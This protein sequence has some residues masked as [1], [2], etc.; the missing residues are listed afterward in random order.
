[1]NRF[2]AWPESALIDI[3]ESIV[4]TNSS[5]EESKEEAK[6]EESNKALCTQIAAIH[7]ACESF[8]DSYAKKRHKSA[9]SVT[10]TSFISFLKCFNQMYA[11][12][13]AEL[14]EKDRRINLGMQKMSKGALDVDV[15]KTELEKLTETLEQSKKATN[16]M[17]AKLQEKSLETKRQGDVMERFR[18]KCDRDVIRIKKERESCEADLAKAMP[19][20]RKAEEAIQA[21]S[22]D[23]ITVIKRLTTPA[24]IIQLVFDCVCIIF[25]RPLDIVKETK[26]TIAKEEITFLQTSHASASH[27]ISSASFLKNLLNFGT[28]RKDEINEETM[29]LLEPY[30][31]LKHFDP[32]VAKKASSAAEGL[33]KWVHSMK[34]YYDSSK[35]AKPKLDA[36]AISEAELE[37]AQRELSDA[38]SKFQHL[39]V[40]LN[41]L[42]SNFEMAMAKKQALVDRSASTAQRIQQASQLI[43][44]LSSERERWQ[45]EAGMF[46][47]KKKTLMGDC[48]LASAFLSYAGPLDYESRM[49]L[50]ED[51]IVQSLESSGVPFTK[52]LNVVEFLVNREKVSNW[53]LNGLASDALS[54]QNAILVCTPS[55]NNSP[56]ILIDPEGQALRWLLEMEKENLPKWGTSTSGDPKLK[57]QLEFNLSE[58]RTMI[59]TNVETQRLDPVLLS[60]LRNRIVRKGDANY[61]NL[62]GSMCA[63]HEKFKLYFVTEE[64]RPGLSA[65]VLNQTRIV[66]FT[67]TSKALEDQLLADVVSKEQNVLETQMRRCSDQIASDTSSLSRLENE[68]LERLTQGEGH[69]LEDASLVSI[70]SETKSAV[71]NVKQKLGAAKQTRKSLREKREIYR[72]VATRGAVLYSTIVSCSTL[73]STYRTSINQFMRIFIKSLERAEKASL[74]P[75]RAEN[76]VQC[77]TRDVVRHVCRGMF[78]NHRVAFLFLLAM[79][80]MNK[81]EIAKNTFDLFLELG[82]D[83]DI[84]TVPKKPFVWITDDQWLRCNALADSVPHFKVLRDMIRNNEVEWRKWCNDDTPETRPVPDYEA[85]LSSGDDAVMGSFAR[86]MIVRALRPDRTV[87]TIARFVSTVICTDESFVTDQISN[88]GAC[89]SFQEMCEEMG[90]NAPALCV[91]SRGSDDVRELVSKNAKRLRR[92]FSSV[93]IGES[94]NVSEAIENAVAEGS[95]L[96]LQ[97][98]ELASEQ[99]MRQL[100]DVVSKIDENSP[101]RVFLSTLDTSKVTIPLTLLQVCVRYACEAP[102]GLRSGM[103]RSFGTNVIDQECLD[104]VDS[105]KWRKL[106]HALAFLHSIVQERRNFGTLG[107]SSSYA[108]NSGDLQSSISFLEHELFDKENLSWNALKFMISETLYGGKITSS[109]DKRLIQT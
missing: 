80:I 16:E 60:L 41:E 84:D 73:H 107:W 72:V 78:Q 37:A 49:K 22:T 53:T 58:G 45:A 7:S 4:T 90:A 105:S 95:W 10:P 79:N 15:M 87:V 35:L 57:D 98:C 103:L 64:S 69:L 32:A 38:K 3:S 101:F 36:L 104:R 56:P 17:I 68:L 11:T 6:K 97:N 52:G 39:K 12:K 86:L 92:N 26:H 75:K 61:V 48:V 55:S 106:L 40:L 2:E 70:L 74:I 13:C 89:A 47:E 62:N 99:V 50:I 85:S 51:Q 81:K 82:S 96:L 66:D 1:M 28:T 88:S 63:C 34:E 65:D 91:S 29:E 83:L 77:L 46:E 19:F 14:N 20:V 8:S 18:D 21:I 67:V 71:A 93:C 33:C 9:A 108:F 76:I 44:G 43:E 5:S 109:M 94:S 42:Q 30:L 54:V 31:N 100:G 25:M 59:V 27:L 23:D 102:S 24:A